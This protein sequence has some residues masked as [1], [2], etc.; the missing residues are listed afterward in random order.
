MHSLFKT[1]LVIFEVIFGR[2]N[3]N[4]ELS[5]LKFRYLESMLIERFKLNKNTYN[6]ATRQV[7]SNFH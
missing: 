5:R 7:A 3:I 4:F 1:M 2:S 6:K